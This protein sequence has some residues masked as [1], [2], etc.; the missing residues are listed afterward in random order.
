MD[1]IRTAAA[2]AR[3]KLALWSRGESEQSAT[4]AEALARAQELAMQ[5]NADLAQREYESA[6]QVDER[7]VRELR[8]AERTFPRAADRYEQAR[9]EIRRSTEKA[10]RLDRL[11]TEQQH[12]TQGFAN[13][14]AATVKAA[15]D[16]IASEMNE[17]AEDGAD[18]MSG[19][20]AEDEDSRLA[21]VN[22]IRS[23]Q[24][25]LAAMPQQ[26]RDVETAVGERAAAAARLRQLQQ[27]AMP[28]DE[29]PAAA[30]AMRDAEEQLREADQRL[31]ERLK[32][33]GDT[34][35]AEIS[36]SLSNYVPETSDAVRGV[37]EQLR[38]AMSRLQRAAST[39]AD[40]VGSAVGE[41]RDAIDGIQTQLKDAQAA[42]LERD[43]LTAARAYAAAAST[44]IGKDPSGAAVHQQNAS[45]ALSR[46]WDATIHEA[47]AARLAGLPTMRPLFAP[48]PDAGA[49][50]P[51]GAAGNV[52]TKFPM[53]F[54]WG[55][56]PWRPMQSLNASP[57]TSDPPGYQDAL[58]AYFEALGVTQPPPPQEPKK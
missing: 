35:A 1:T 57:R 47:A 18:D 13:P 15:Q 11:A 56:L 53:F 34:M 40:D 30:R 58:Q 5:A 55:R 42:L 17:A 52:T 39:G 49:A 27:Q 48:P 41:V 3:R 24:E 31:A 12:L 23:A 46:A 32:P 38:P 4:E 2:A 22:A 54:G 20:A 19:E 28:P 21:A 43:P 50:A 9:Q 37:I 6:E 36:W 51:Q 44:S 45:V 25:R 7:I 16:R 29:Q 33:L 14:D 10:K 26:L 8:L